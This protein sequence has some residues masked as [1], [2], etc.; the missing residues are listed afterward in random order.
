MFRRHDLAWL[1][2]SGWRAA[3][4]RALPEHAGV[5][6]RW[7]R[8]DWPAVVRR[9]DA[10]AG[11]GEV[12]LGLALP[13]HPD[14][15]HK[16]R[17]ALRVPAGDVART[18]PALALDCLSAAL[19]ALLPAL[20]P[21]AWRKDLRLLAADSAD[22]TFRVYGSL[23]LQAVTAQAYVSPTSDIDLLFYPASSA[24]LGLGLALLRKH[25]GSLPLDGE[26]VFPNGQAVA[27]K[28]WL[29]AASGNARVLVKEQNG[30]RLVSRDAL[31]ATLEAA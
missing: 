30:V 18:T 15:G 6:E 2:A 13:P 19:P 24:Q 31:L 5:I 7:Q 9:D 10:H 12:C 26:I 14:S 3:R 21:D 4:A 29:A 1:S 25:A 28:E 16:L 8:E 17:I 11:A 23:A 22:L 27:W 20:L